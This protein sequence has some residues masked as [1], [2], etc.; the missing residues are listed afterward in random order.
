MFL[1]A[2]KDLGVI[3]CSPR[4]RRVITGDEPKEA[5][6]EIL[7][8][9]HPDERADLVAAIAAHSEAIAPLRLRIR[10]RDHLGAFRAV[11]WR[12]RQSGDELLCEVHEQPPAGL[13]ATLEEAEREII[14]L[15]VNDA[16]LEEILTRAC[17]LF[18]EFVPGALC[19][20]LLVNH[21]NTALIPGA[22]PSLPKEYMDALN[23]LEIGPNVGCC[24]TAVA[25]KKVIITQDIETDP[26]WA[27]FRALASP[28]GLRSCW[29]T[30]L[31]NLRRQAVGTFAVYHKEPHLPPLTELHVARELSS[32]VQI[33]IAWRIDRKELLAAQGRADD[34]NAAKSAFLAKMS[35][36]LRTPLNAII[37]FSDVLRSDASGRIS[38]AK[39]KEYFDFI[40]QSGTNLLAMVD[41]LLDLS[42]IE[43]GK[44]AMLEGSFAL[45][46]LLHE[47]LTYLEAGGRNKIPQIAISGVPEGLM[48]AGDR[49]AIGRVFL[50]I[51]SNAVKHTPES[52]TISV[53]A[54]AGDGFTKLVFCDTGKGIPKEHLSRLGQPYA[55]VSS[56]SSLTDTGTGLGLYISRSIVEQHGG[57]L[58]IESTVGVGTTVTVMLPAAGVAPHRVA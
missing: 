30:P 33:A 52:G 7:T 43:A 14:N 6:R 24:G 19:S 26:K 39:R 20:V 34:A 13:S 22:A 15:V 8:Y 10:L 25:E 21:T 9:V 16:A 51:L 28:H 5:P 35:H 44:A 1:L 49:L 58:E 56:E 37:G 54:C 41:G 3:Y 23:G 4:L 38:E 31:L 42:R 46:A 32:A 18:E 40:N 45:S 11:E 12:I 57:T 17:S 53:S 29:S 2:T 55:R 48:V 36:E 50:N 27:Q 47:C